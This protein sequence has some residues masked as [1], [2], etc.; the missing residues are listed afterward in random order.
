MWN[1]M[2]H[3]GQLRQCSSNVLMVQCPDCAAQMEHTCGEDCRSFMALP[4]EEQKTKRSGSRS[5][6]RTLR[7]PSSARIAKRD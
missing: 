7:Q 5:V 3:R 6:K 2:R 4:A 1:G